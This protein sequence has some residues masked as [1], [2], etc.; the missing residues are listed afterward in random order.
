MG[1]NSKM[2][3]QISLISVKAPSKLPLHTGAVSNRKAPKARSF[4]S[5]IFSYYIKQQRKSKL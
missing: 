2:H 5:L 4:S 3:I 1:P